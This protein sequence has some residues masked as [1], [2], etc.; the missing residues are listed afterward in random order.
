MFLYAVLEK[1]LEQERRTEQRMVGD[2]INRNNREIDR[3]QRD[4]LGQKYANKDERDL[5]VQNISRLMQE[6]DALRRN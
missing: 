6:N 2:Q 4:L 3:L 1:L 5:V